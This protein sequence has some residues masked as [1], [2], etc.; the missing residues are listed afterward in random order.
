[1]DNKIIKF[2]V[3]VIRWYI[4]MSFRLIKLLLIAFSMVYFYASL[5]ITAVTHSMI[6]DE[7]KQIII[8]QEMMHMADSSFYKK[9][10]QK[11]AVYKIQGFE[12]LYEEVVIDA[13]DSAEF[14]KRTGISKNISKIFQN[15]SGLSYEGAKLNKIESI[16][17]D[18]TGKDII[19]AVRKPVIN[20]SRLA[21]VNVN[22]F[23]DNSIEP[24]IMEHISR[25]TIK[26]GYKMSRFLNDY[27]INLMTND[28]FKRVIIDKRNM[29]V[30]VKSLLTNTDKVITYGANHSKGIIELLAQQGF[31]KFEEEITVIIY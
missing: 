1:M 30:V 17:A 28:E 25:T 21:E 5:P 19:D 23:K 12:H 26:L 18:I 31:R 6:N 9:V 2:L 16:R 4:K 24:H 14:Q 15:N 13:K 8:I 7:T 22:T 27:N 10:N 11:V 29:H 20:T 3:D